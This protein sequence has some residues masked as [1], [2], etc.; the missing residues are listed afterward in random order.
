MT[1]STYAVGAARPNGWWGMVVFVAGE[2]TL[3]LM[4]FATYFYLRLQSMHWPPTHIAKPPVLTP[5]L[6]TLAL[7]STS[8]PM[9]RAWTAGAMGERRRAWRLLALAGI[10]QLAYLVWQVHDF[11]DLTRSTRPQ[12]SAYASIYLTIVAVDHLHVLLGVLLTAWLL[13]RL[14]TRITPYRLR[15]LQAVTFYWHAVNAITIAVLAVQ[16]SPYV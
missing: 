2:T 16:L 1:S 3:F 4:L 8:I 6:L 7:V 11:V 10:V 14:A 9:Q 15:G 13:V 5:V 12:D